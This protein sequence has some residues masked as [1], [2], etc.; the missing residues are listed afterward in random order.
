MGETESEGR[1]KRGS[2]RGDK[3][4]RCTERVVTMLCLCFLC[5]HSPVILSSYSRSS[6]V[7]SLLPS[8]CWFSVS[9]PPLL[10]SPL[11]SSHSGI[12]IDDVN[13]DFRVSDGNGNDVIPIDRNTGAP[14]STLYDIYIIFIFYI[15]YLNTFV[16]VSSVWI[17]YFFC[18]RE[19]CMWWIFQQQ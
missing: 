15:Y 3:K 19:Y 1:R 6:L 7:S 16:F 5:L 18:F 10:L 8:H 14:V 13:F 2:R 11:L 9:S 17:Y 4:K 12:W